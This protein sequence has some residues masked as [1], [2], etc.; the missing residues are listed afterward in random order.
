MA[1]TILAGVARKVRLEMIDSRQL[2]GTEDLEVAL[3]RSVVLTLARQ[4][5]PLVRVGYPAGTEDTHGADLELWVR[6][7][8]LRVGFRFQSKVLRPLQ[9]FAGK[10]EELDHRIGGR[11]SGERQIDVLIENSPRPLNPAYLFYNGL[12]REPS[13]RSACCRDDEWSPRNGQLGLTFCSAHRIR[14]LLDGSVRLPK[15]L[16]AVLPRSLPLPC[17]ATCIDPSHVTPW[18]LSRPFN[19]V[20]DFMSRMPGWV[21]GADLGLD[22]LWVVADERSPRGTAAL[23]TLDQLGWAVRAV[24]PDSTNYV[25]MLLEAGEFTGIEE[26]LEVPP[27]MPVI[28]IDLEPE[29]LS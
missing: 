15:R 14:A 23:E 26:L 11:S 12:E 2:V 10:Y 13:I 27:I 1:H 19:P 20:A 28:V 24:T 9:R 18:S 17:A 22:P 6:S 8:G 7:Q 29:D 4:R 3:T 16:E 5:S 21:L 25:E